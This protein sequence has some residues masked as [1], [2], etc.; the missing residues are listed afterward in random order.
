MSITKNLFVFA[1]QIYDLFDAVQIYDL[2]DAAVLW[3][4]VKQ[5]SNYSGNIAWTKDR[6]PNATLSQEVLY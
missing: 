3:R 5:L 4:V 1:V 2:F 6:K